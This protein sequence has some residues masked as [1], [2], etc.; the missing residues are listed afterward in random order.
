MRSRVYQA[1]CSPFRNPLDDKERRVVRFGTTRMAE[2]IG[3]ALARTAG[4]KDPPIRW[5][6]VHDDPWFDNQVATIRLEGRK[7]TMWIDKTV[8]SEAAEGGEGR[9]HLERVFE[10]PLAWRFS[11]RSPRPTC[12]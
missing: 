3:R 8:P 11:A 9:L 4:V 6:F 10:R 7:A 2:G 1:T 5:R 12:A